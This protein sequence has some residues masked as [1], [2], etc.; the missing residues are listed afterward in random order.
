[1]ACGL[2]LLVD[3]S[4][5]PATTSDEA[6]KGL[7]DLQGLFATRPDARV[8]VL[9]LSGPVGPEHD[10]RTLSRIARMGGGTLTV[11]GDLDATTAALSAVLRR[12]TSTVARGVR[13]DKAELR[14]EREAA[15]LTYL[16][17][18]RLECRASK[19]CV[20]VEVGDVL[21]GEV[22]HLL[23][24]IETRARAGQENYR[25]PLGI[26][27]VSY[28]Y[29][30]VLALGFVR[31][32]LLMVSVG[33]SGGGLCPTLM[34][35]D[36]AAWAC[37]A[38]RLLVKQGVK[39]SELAK[40]EGLRAWLAER[41][42]DA[43][44]RL[45]DMP[46][47]G[48]QAGAG[49]AAVFQ[50]C[51]FAVLNIYMQQQPF[52]MVGE[53]AWPSLRDPRMNL[54]LL[55]VGA[56]EALQGL[57]EADEP[58]EEDSLFNKVRWPTCAAHMRPELGNERLRGAW[59]CV[60]VRSLRSPGETGPSSGPSEPTT[61]NK[62]S[63]TTISRRF[64]KRTTSIP[65]TR[66]RRR[67]GR[68]PVMPSTTAR[69]ARGGRGSMP[70]LPSLCR[71]LKGS[72]GRKRRSGRLTPTSRRAR[73]RVGGA[74][75]SAGGAGAAT[76]AAGRRPLDRRAPKAASPSMLERGVEERPG[77]PR[78]GTGRVPPPGLRSASGRCWSSCRARSLSG[79]LTPRT[80]RGV[81]TRVEAFDRLMRDSA[82]EKGEGVGGWCG[83]WC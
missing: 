15:S 67:A 56:E 44:M 13:V 11:A 78:S 40:V 76:L 59:P 19:L 37:L 35:A 4:A 74:R 51:A 63:P 68:S 58:A 34:Q 31:R 24:R 83:A 39:A 26:L 62:R 29:E 21:A 1:V 60:C 77:L 48:A 82:M 16:G 81:A 33:P 20:S 80:R 69:A 41:L 54:G 75:A 72:R 52:N 18:G 65:P 57:Q 45:L 3:G 38:G 50:R 30:D 79:S 9:D 47:Q 23:L 6:T 70:L 22:A 46:G 61:A 17:G 2:L 53:S 14:C 25:G 49:D 32:A 71:Y 7:G 28:T 10:T 73:G 66:S 36:P 8:H 5:V 43:L 42:P 64:L 55:G 12:L 27:A